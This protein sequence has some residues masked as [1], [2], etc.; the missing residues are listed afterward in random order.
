MYIF[1][2]T[3]VLNQS[4]LSMIWQGMLPRLG[5]THEEATTTITHPL[6]IKELLGGGLKGNNTTHRLPEELKWMVFKV[7]QRAHS[8]YFKKV[9][10]RNPNVDEVGVSMTPVV[11]DEF[12]DDRKVQYNWPYDFFSLIESI[13]LDATVEFSNRDYT[14][15]TEGE[16]PPIDGVSATQESIDLSSARVDEIIPEAPVFNEPMENAEE[17]TD[18]YN[19]LEEAKANALKELIDGSKLNQEVKKAIV[20]AAEEE[21]AGALGNLRDVA[22][23]GQMADILGGLDLSS[24]DA[25]LS[26]LGNS[27]LVLT[28]VVGIPQDELMG[29]SNG[30][31][32]GYVTDAAQGAL[33]ASFIELKN[34]YSVYTAQV[35][36]Y[37]ANSPQ[38]NSAMANLSSLMNSVEAASS[39]LT[40]IGDN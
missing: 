10:T 20:D 22:Q 29:A 38:A 30:V 13:S 26:Q 5:H 18:Q 27:S 17:I 37:G 2:F 32:Q 19:E 1:E 31:L 16:L 24:F 11:V 15:W 35:E 23:T 9:V 40:I 25:L 33:V 28:D 39:I 3:H 34:S 8:S 14:G 36:Q 12:G 6:L 4:D 7:K 21:V